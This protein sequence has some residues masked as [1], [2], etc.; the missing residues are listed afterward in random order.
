MYQHILVPV[1]DSALSITTVGQAV[2]LA[3]RLDARITF[4]HARPDF[5]ATSD[6]AV[7]HAMSPKGFE[8]M[9][10]GNAI[11]VLARAESEARMARLAF[12]SIARTTDRPYEGILDAAREQGCD[13]IFMASHGKRG[14][15]GLLMGSQTRKVLEHATIP[16]LVSSTESNVASPEMERALAIVQGEH[17]SMGA[18]MHGLRHLLAEAR[19]SGEPVDAGLLR[20]IV[21]Y[22]KNFTEALHHPKEDAY[23]FDR[24]KARSSDSL[25]VLEVLHAQHAEEGGFIKALD[26]AV[27]AY[28]AAPG[29]ARLE[30]LAEAGD[31]YA[32]RLWEHMS[33]EEKF[34]LPACRQHLKG[35]DWADIANAFQ[36]NGDPRFDEDRKVGFDKLFLRLVSL[37]K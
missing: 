17:R 9:A 11:A 12:T 4:F 20:S 22:F 8:D 29:A 10:P 34:I 28:A 27:E 37:T 15:K 24:L 3:R 31:R 19:V 1:D 25:E 6:G 2:A 16:V 21:F 5:S 36:S 33:L 35:N 26:A 18:V 7:L 14:L 30:A 23:L 32:E 13:L